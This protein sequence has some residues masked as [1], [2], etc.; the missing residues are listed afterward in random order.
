M[1][2][3]TD[4]VRQVLA[5]N[6]NKN[7]VKRVLNPNDYPVLNLGAKDFSGRQQSG[8]HLMA[9]GQT[10]GKYVVYP[11]IMYDDATKT[12][13]NWGMER[14]FR[15]AMKNGEFIEFDSPEEADW[16]SRNYKLV[17]PEEMR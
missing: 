2:N 8:T 3:D 4:K 6:A 15:E 5:K 17:W 1:N 14:G 9:W 10:D 7:F 13:T 12:L 11:T 16:F